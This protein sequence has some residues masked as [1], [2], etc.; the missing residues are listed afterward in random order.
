MFRFS[1]P[2]SRRLPAS[3]QDFPSIF[4]TFNIFIC[5]I[6]SNYT[7]NMG[8]NKI[9]TYKFRLFLTEFF[10]VI[11]YSKVQNLNSEK[12]PFLLKNTLH[13]EKLHFISEKGQFL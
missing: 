6:L 3:A 12:S 4:L 7:K 5:E 13:I 1:S 9:P 11:V 10:S 8:N 2:G